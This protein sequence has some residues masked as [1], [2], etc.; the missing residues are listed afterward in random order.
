[1]EGCAFKYELKGMW[2]EG[3]TWKSG[4]GT[5]HPCA[6]IDDKMGV[7]LCSCWKIPTRQKHRLPLQDCNLE[8][9]SVIIEGN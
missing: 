6:E 1:M 2:L 9:S 3:G 5:L 7:M 8:E 4:V